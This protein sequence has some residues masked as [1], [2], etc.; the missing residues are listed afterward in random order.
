MRIYIASP[1]ILVLL[2]IGFL[3]LLVGCAVD[4]LSDRLAGWVEAG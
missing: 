2:L 4:F 1:F 3:L